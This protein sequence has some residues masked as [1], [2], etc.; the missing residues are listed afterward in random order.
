MHSGEEEKKGFD[1]SSASCLLGFV[2]FPKQ[3]VVYIGKPKQTV[4]VVNIT[5]IHIGV[6]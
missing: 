2:A 3:R 6:S 4:V 1:F 5:Q